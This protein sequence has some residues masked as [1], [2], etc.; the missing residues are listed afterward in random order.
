MP[1]VKNFYILPEWI[2]PG[3]VIGCAAIT[4]GLAGTSPVV[5]AHGAGKQGIW[6][7]PMKQNV[8]E[9]QMMIDKSTL[10]GQHDDPAQRF[11][12]LLVK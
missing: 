10:V 5:E 11:R 1:E 9:L 7:D 12:E 4:I 3:L 2:E 6:Y 8:P